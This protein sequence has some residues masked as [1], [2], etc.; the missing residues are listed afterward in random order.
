M[1]HCSKLIDEQ[2]K[3]IK[4]DF[5][6][7]DK[8][9]EQKIKRHFFMIIAKNKTV[10]FSYN[11]MSYMILDTNWVWL[12]KHNSLLGERLTSIENKSFNGRFRRQ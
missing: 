6:F 3:E 12:F 4:N 10:N 2:E 11:E 5:L 1:F 8:T 9:C 7:I